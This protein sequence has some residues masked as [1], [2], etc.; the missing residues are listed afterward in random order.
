MPNVL[1]SALQRDGMRI[2]PETLY[3]LN[4]YQRPGA[5]VRLTRQC[6]HPL[7]HILKGLSLSS[8]FTCT[9]PS[10]RR[11]SRPAPAERRGAR[12]SIRVSNPARALRRPPRQA[13]RTRLRAVGTLEVVGTLIG[14]HRPPPGP[15]PKRA[16]GCPC[17]AACPGGRALRRARRAAPSTGALQEPSGRGRTMRCK[18]YVYPLSYQPLF[19]GFIWGVHQG[20]LPAQA[21]CFAPGAVRSALQPDPTGPTMPWQDHGKHFVWACMAWQQ[22]RMHMFNS[23]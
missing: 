20:R 6:Q 23:V 13:R 21:V 11:C 14:R 5:Q 15:A 7:L 3:V 16:R 22:E 9:D 19:I 12:C 17:R 2:G 1:H 10:C 18:G 4:R 8:S